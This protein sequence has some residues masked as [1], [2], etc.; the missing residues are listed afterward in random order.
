MA[1]G[2]FAGLDSY[3]GIRF[4]IGSDLHYGW[5]RLDLDNGYPNQALGYLTEWAY[6]SV[7]NAPLAA[8]VVPEPSTWAL[9][10]LGAAAI[11]RFRR[12]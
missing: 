5:I 8:G 11:L 1:Y 10:A 7:P 9:F 6:N 4:Y 12:S 3:L 2:P